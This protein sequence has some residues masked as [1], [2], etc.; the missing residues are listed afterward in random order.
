MVGCWKPYGWSS[1]LFFELQPVLGYVLEWLYRPYFEQIGPKRVHVV[2][3]RSAYSSSLRS[4]SSSSR[5]MAPTRMRARE[6]SEL[7]KTEVGNAA[8]PR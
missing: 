1:W 4:C 3:S 2:M 8:T 5:S 6:P 7:M